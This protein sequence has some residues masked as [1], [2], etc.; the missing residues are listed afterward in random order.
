MVNPCPD[1]VLIAKI[2]AAQ[3]A[4]AIAGLLDASG[5]SASINVILFILGVTGDYRDR[6]CLI[7]FCARHDGLMSEDACKRLILGAKTNKCS[8]CGWI[9]HQARHCPN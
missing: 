9:G 4:V 1:V 5:I 8:Q 2:E 3:T 6:A 7:D